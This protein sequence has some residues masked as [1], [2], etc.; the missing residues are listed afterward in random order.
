[1]VGV[2]ALVGVALTG[3]A[4]AQQTDPTYEVV[5]SDVIGERQFDGSGAAVA[6]S[7]D[8]TVIAVGAPGNN[9]D[10]NDK[11]HVRVYGLTDGDWVQI[12]ADID[13]EGDTDRSGISVALSADGMTVA[14]GAAQND[15][16]ADN[17]GHVRV[18]SLDAGN[19]VQVGS[20]IDGEAEGDK[21]GFSVALSADGTT[22]AIGAPENDGTGANAGHVRVYAVSADRWSQVGADI[23]GEA[24]GDQSGFSVSLS[25]DGTRVAIGA[26]EAQGQ[27]MGESRFDTGHVRVY[28]LSAGSWGQV[29][30]DIDGEDQSDRS[31][32]SVSLSGDGTTV[33]IGARANDEAAQGAGHVRVFGLDAGAW[34]Q[35]GADI[36]GEGADD[37]SGNTNSVALSDDGT[38]L[39]IGAANNDGAAE[40]AGH[41]RVFALDADAWTQVGVDVDGDAVGQRMGAAVAV[42]ADGSNLIGGADGYDDG[43]SPDAGR[44]QVYE[45]VTPVPPEEPPEEP[46]VEEPPVE[47]PP[48][49]E[50]AKTCAGIEVTVDIDAGDEPTEGDDV[51]L[52]TPADDDIDGRGGSDVIC[53]LQGDDAIS[54]GD[55]ADQIFAGA[56]ADTVDGGAGNDFI[57]AGSGAD[58]VNGGLANDRIFGGADNDIIMGDGGY[59]RLRGGTGD[60]DIDGGTH[61][62]QIWGNQGR[63]TLKGG[64]GNDILRGGFALD[65]FDGGAGTNDACT[66]TDPNGVV[67]TRIG[68]ERGVFG[69]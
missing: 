61:D 6:M 45:L 2:I 24:E 56:G 26:P 31:G 68:C 53:G 44:A 66:V 59:D 60:D 7:D 4:A 52:G 43:A 50:P 15:G 46:P 51:I 13:G 47:E 18:Y 17:A 54:G 22:V 41:V 36:E 55:G 67:E 33:A 14:I 8:G 57:A 38:T 49:E 27:V 11:G 10:G 23:D 9:A 21:S 64:N 39:V 69:L 34:S 37:Q 3:S 29:G 28:E 20:D 63:D 1:M 58:I 40:N 65:S 62:D 25:N 48:A 16:A 42:S 12:G 35:I 5:G 19:W 30:A 32:T